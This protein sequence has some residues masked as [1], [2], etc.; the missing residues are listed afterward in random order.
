MKMD[1]ATK[2]WFESYD[3]KEIVLPDRFLPSKE[4]IEY[5]NDVIFQ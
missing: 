5:H 3:E 2:M 1:E 4:F